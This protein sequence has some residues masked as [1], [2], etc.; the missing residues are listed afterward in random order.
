MDYPLKSH[1][2]QEG[3]SHLPRMYFPHGIQSLLHHGSLEKVWCSNMLILFLVNASNTIMGSLNEEQKR[4]WICLVEDCLLNEEF[5]KGTKPKMHHQVQMVGGYVKH[6]L[7]IFVEIID[8]QK[9]I[10]S[11]SSSSIG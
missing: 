6:C 11:R 8:R 4:D 1:S 7:Q 3:H 10:S 2:M 9:S 5:L